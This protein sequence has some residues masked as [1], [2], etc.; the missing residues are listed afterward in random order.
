MRPKP[1]RSFAIATRIKPAP[2]GVDLMLKIGT[3]LL[4]TFAA[5]KS[6]SCR[7]RRSDALQLA[8]RETP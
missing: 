3:A 1:L 7:E 2:T 4:M 6:A 5:C 8:T